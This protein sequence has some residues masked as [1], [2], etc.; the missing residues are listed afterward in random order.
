M[1]SGGLLLPSPFQL[2]FLSTML[3]SYLHS[4]QLDFF[5]LC[6]V[7]GNILILFLR[8]LFV[9]SLSL[10]RFSFLFSV[11]VYAVLLPFLFYCSHFPFL[12]R[13]LQRR[14]QFRQH[15]GCWSADCC[16]GL[17]LGSLSFHVARSYCW[18]TTSD[19][20]KQCPC[21]FSQGQIEMWSISRLLL[22]SEVFKCWHLTRAAERP[23]LS[24][25]SRVPKN[26]CIGVKFPGT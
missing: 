3:S 19:K 8:S 22:K 2:T 21:A 20:G 18:H 17:V 11:L 15:W 23:L 13:L 10:Y 7:A 6:F 9:L 4:G 24:E 26:I 16:G 5:A 1:H 25:E 14:E 12:E